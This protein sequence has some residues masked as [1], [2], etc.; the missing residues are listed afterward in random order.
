LAMMIFNSIWRLKHIQ[1][2]E[3]HLQQWRCVGKS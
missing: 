3:M 1:R 2:S